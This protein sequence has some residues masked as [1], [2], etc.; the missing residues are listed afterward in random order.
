MRYWFIFVCVKNFN[1]ALLK[2]Q[3]CEPSIFYSKDAKF[4]IFFCLL[5][6]LYVISNI[7]QLIRN[8]LRSS[9]CHFLMLSLLIYNKLSYKLLQARLRFIYDHCLEHSLPYTQFNS[10]T[11]DFEIIINCT[12]HYFSNCH[13]FKGYVWYF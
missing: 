13:N 12:M 11:I 8:F 3:N 6:I 5:N 4:I 9:N 7:K 10:Y 2:S 1:I